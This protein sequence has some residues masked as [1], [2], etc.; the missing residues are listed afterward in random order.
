[1]LKHLPVTSSGQTEYYLSQDPIGDVCLSVNG[2]TLIKDIE[3]IKDQRKLTIIVGKT[4]ANTVDIKITDQVVAT[5]VKG[6]S[7]KGF[8][9]ETNTVPSTGVLTGEYIRGDNI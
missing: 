6:T 5:Y 4:I 1:M 7:I 8:I 9:S 3:Y 2:V